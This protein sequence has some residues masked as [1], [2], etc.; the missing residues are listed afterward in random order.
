MGLEEEDDEALVGV[1]GEDAQGP[2][3]QY[4]HFVC[5]LGVFLRQKGS[6]AT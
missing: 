3:L 6:V 4:A 5:F 2:L 1:E